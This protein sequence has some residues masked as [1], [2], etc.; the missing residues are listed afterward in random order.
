MRV[1]TR[2]EAC[3]D[4]HRR[5][6]KDET[7]RASNGFIRHRAASHEMM[8]GPKSMVTCVT[9]HHP[10]LGVLYSNEKGMASAT[11]SE[12]ETCHKGARESLQ[13]A[14]LADAHGDMACIECPRPPAA[15]TAVTRSMFSGDMRSHLFTINTAM[16]AEQLPRGAAVGLSPFPVRVHLHRAVSTVTTAEQ[17]PVLAETRD[18]VKKWLP[19]TKLLE[20][21]GAENHFFPKH[22]PAETAA[23][24]DAPVPDRMA[25]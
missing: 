2:S 20:I 16:D 4:C 14:P 11:R 19:E 10:H 7:I 6:A 13:N 25:V 1:D 17:G 23:V 3:A 18:L 21:P 12:C 5:G 24:L 9:C 22:V 15:R 8:A